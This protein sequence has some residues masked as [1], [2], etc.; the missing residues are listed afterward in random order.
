MIRTLFMVLL[1]ASSS[2]QMGGQTASSPLKS[3][4]VS[5]KSGLIAVPSPKTTVI[6]GVAWKTDQLTAPYLSKKPEPHSQIQSSQIHE[7]PKPVDQ[8]SR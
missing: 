5:S 2:Y 8:V 3:R 6:N 1:L 7:R 4:P